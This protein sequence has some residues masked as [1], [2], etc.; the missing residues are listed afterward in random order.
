[1]PFGRKDVCFDGGGVRAAVD[2][3]VCYACHGEEFEGVFD[4]GCVGE[5]EET[6]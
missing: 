4:E 5:G 1:M 6:L 3:D 2:E